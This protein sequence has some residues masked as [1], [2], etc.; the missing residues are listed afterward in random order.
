MIEED[1]GDQNV[2]DRLTWYSTPFFSYRRMFVM[3]TSH[4]KLLINPTLIFAQARSSGMCDS[5]D[6]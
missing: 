5:C 6:D 1:E 3:I 4:R 2:Y